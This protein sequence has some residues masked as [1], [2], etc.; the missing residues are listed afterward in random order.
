MSNNIKVSLYNPRPESVHEDFSIHPQI[1]DRLWQDLIDSKM[2]FPEQHYLIRGE[3]GSGK[4]TL[5]AQLHKSIL[6]NPPL[7][8]LQ[9]LFFNEEEYSIRHLYRLW[10]RIFELLSDKGLTANALVTQ[11]RSMSEEIDKNQDYEKN[12]GNKLFDFLE[13]NDIHLLLFIDNFDL[14]L[15][16]LSTAECHRFRKILQTS[17]R[18]RIIAAASEVP[19]SF[20]QYEHPF[21]EFFKI[22]RLRPLSV[23]GTQA[24]LEQL[25][26]SDSKN[27]ISSAT[28][29]IEAIRRITNGNTRCIVL[30]SAI[31]TENPRLSTREL[32]SDILDKLTP[33]YKFTMDDL[34]AQ[35][36]QIVEA[37]AL[38][39]DAI[40]VKELANKL[41][42]ASKV[43]SAQ[44]AQLVKNDLIVKIKTSTKNN[45]Y[46]LKDRLF[47]CWYLL[48]LGRNKDRLKLSTILDF[49]ENWIR[50]NDQE[51]KNTFSEIPLLNIDTIPR[52]AKPTLP[53]TSIKSRLSPGRAPLRSAMSGDQQL[54]QR[55]Y[56]AIETAQ[57]KVAIQF[58][59]KI[60]NTDHFALAVAYHQGTNDYK[61][62][63]TH[64]QKAGR[65]GQ[66][67]ALNN[68]GLL[69]L[70]QQHNPTAAKKAF[71]EAAKKGSNLAEYNLGLYH[72]QEEKNIAVAMDHFSKATSDGNSE[73]LLPLAQLY[74]HQFKKT[75]QA[76]LTLS[77][78][79]ATGNPMANYQL[80]LIYLNDKNDE[81]SAL[82]YFEEYLLHPSTQTLSLSLGMTLLKQEAYEFL[83]T[84]FETKPAI[85]TTTLPLYYA[86]QK[87]D[88]N[89]ESDEILR[90]GHELEITVNEIVK[91]IEN[92]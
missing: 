43:I 19:S 39:Y 50:I 12:I 70:H 44:L 22:V 20:Y 68:L 13:N 29:R 42:I 66:A 92:N 55:A 36:Q 64:Y 2:E 9:P 67:D 28:A 82:H 56:Q 77:E 11:M 1:Y 14:I 48:R 5:L 58:L 59:Q 49:T 65:A 88:I 76:I 21:Y 81:N 40:S 71:I 24:L 83:N 45:F 84:L 34:P 23:E 53:V 85:K 26:P 31:L 79:A 16:K 17:P 27:I 10:E 80:G 33:I 54:R 75:E 91:M 72:L 3:H 63:I 61:R 73:A 6:Q 74:Y 89:A 37:I 46:H 15:E 51:N 62:A 8:S 18:L 60:K 7:S 47:N 38:H 25:I 41:R 30:L 35:Q 4:T 90:M 87:C 78:A 57:Y 69:H 52:L 32:F 86:L